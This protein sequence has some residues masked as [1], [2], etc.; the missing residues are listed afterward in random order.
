MR[1]LP[2]LRVL[3][4]ISLMTLGAC[5]SSSKD[6][7][8]PTEAVTE[9]ADTAADTEAVE[10]VAETSAA[11]ETE[12]ADSAAASDT[13]AGDASSIAG[14]MASSFKDSTG[15]DL[16]AE[17]S[18]CMADSILSSFSAKELIDLGQSK[19][20]F[21]GLSDA[22]KARAVASFQK[23]P[24]LLEEA[25]FAGFK[26]SIPDL[27]EAQGRCGADA[28]GKEF[29]AEEMVALSTKPDAAK[30]PAVL[31]KIFTAFSS[32]DGLLTGLL[33]AGVKQAGATDVQAKCAA[34]VMVK[35]LD[36]A[37]L[38]KF[39]TDPNSVDA[40]TQEK[41]KTGIQACQKL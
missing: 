3:A 2:T 33:S 40:A 16:T 17:Q 11:V 23:C 22:D 41:L 15:V 32:C 6:T 29:T 24:G 10:T 34:D 26:S 9:A 13:A 27:D 1:R 36:A 19:A 7:T 4:V 21:D 38:V 12:A 28:I 5:S 30:D 39:S 31:T 20:G 37:T 8:A 18:Q 35:E 14:V 25:L